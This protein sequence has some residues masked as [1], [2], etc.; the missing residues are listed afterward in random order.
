MLNKPQGV[1]SATE[2]SRYETVLDCLGTGR[3]DLLP[4]RPPDIDTEGIADYQRRR[5]GARSTFT[6]KT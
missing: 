2:D 3:G 4:C 1:V 5:F 6:K